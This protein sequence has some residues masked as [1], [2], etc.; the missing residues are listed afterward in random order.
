VLAQIADAYK[1]VAGL[2][3]VADDTRRVP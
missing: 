2:K 1:Q 3:P